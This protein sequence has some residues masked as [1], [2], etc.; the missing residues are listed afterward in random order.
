[1]WPEFSA[2]GYTLPPL[3]LDE[4]QWQYVLR[5]EMQHI[6]SRD[7]VLKFLYF[8]LAAVFWWNPISNI[9]VG[10]LDALLEL[11]C[12]SKVT[13]KMDEQEKKEYLSTMLSVVRQTMRDKWA[14][15][16]LHAGFMSPLAN[17]KQRFANV[18][19]F[20][21]DGSRTARAALSAGMVLVF[22]LSY[23]VIFQPSFDPPMEDMDDVVVITEENSFILHTPEGEYHMYIGSEFYGVIPPEH[24]DGMPYCDLEIIEG[25]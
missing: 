6:R 3:E 15:M 20:D 16:E 11:R 25:S 19:E 8:F 14:R 1:M 22:A 5:H 4:Q 13:G 23:F 10:E 21:A 17:A 24:L 12:D 2:P 18:L 9:F 7:L